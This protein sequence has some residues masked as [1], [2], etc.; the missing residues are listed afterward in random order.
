MF[1]LASF[2]DETGLDFD[3]QSGTSVE[4]ADAAVSDWF[5]YPSQYLNVTGV[6][7]ECPTIFLDWSNVRLV[8]TYDHLYGLEIKAPSTKASTS[9]AP[10]S[11]R[12]SA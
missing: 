8:F 4:E 11:A 5:S 3:V 12:F 1:S 7:G 9:S 10:R 2:L 6:G